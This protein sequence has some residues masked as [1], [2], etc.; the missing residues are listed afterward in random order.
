MT[1]EQQDNH[2]CGSTDR[3]GDPVGFAVHDRGRD[4]PQVSQRAFGFDF[5]TEEFGYLADQ[6]RQGDSVHIAVADRFGK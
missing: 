6:D 3:K 2:Q 5:E 4:L 1:F